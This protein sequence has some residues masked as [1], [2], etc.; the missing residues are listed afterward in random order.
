MLSILAI[1]Y[2]YVFYLIYKI[3][4]AGKS[5]L[6]ELREKDTEEGIK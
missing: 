6:K 5:L 3:E 2:C 4:K 1:S